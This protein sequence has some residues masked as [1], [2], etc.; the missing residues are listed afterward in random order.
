MFKKIGSPTNI[1]A[2]NFK[3]SATDNIVCSHCKAV[4]GRRNGRFSKFSGSN[5]VVVSI[6][7]FICP[8]CNE[9]SEVK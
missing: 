8:Q 5:V 6:S 7:K 4:V 9:T 1:E 3:K 2:V